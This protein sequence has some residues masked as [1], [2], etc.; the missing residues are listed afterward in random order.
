[1]PLD[2]AKKRYQRYL[3][4]LLILLCFAIHNYRNNQKFSNWT[5]TLTLSFFPINADNSTAAQKHIDNLTLDDIA[6]I[7]T[8][9]N[10]QAKLYGVPNS[11]ITRIALEKNNLTP[12]P[13]FP[14]THST[15]S[16]IFWSIKLRLWHTAAQFRSNNQDTDVAIYALYHNPATSPTLNDSVGLKEGRIVVANIFADE[17]YS[18]S[19]QVVITHEIFHTFSATDKYNPKTNYPLYPIGFAEPDKIPLLPQNRASLMGGR[20]PISETKARIPTSLNQVMINRTTAF[21]IQWI[22][23]YTP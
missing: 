2:H 20:I 10:N 16:N 5:N 7:Q 1:M 6:T 19:N 9:I 8:F 22:K 14:D 21:E 15:L 18:G 13:A 17:A 4:L 11:Q 23:Q 3:V 12:P